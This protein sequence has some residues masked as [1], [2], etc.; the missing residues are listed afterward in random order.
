MKSELKVYSGIRPDEAVSL[1]RAV[2]EQAKRIELLKSSGSNAAAARTLLECYSSMMGTIQGAENKVSADP[3]PTPA[4]VAFKQQIK[5]GQ[6]I[7]SALGN[8]GTS[9]KDES[10][11]NVAA[12][13]RHK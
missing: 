6:S 7:F 2:E 1:A 10:D 8:S 12:E 4:N 9:P 5:Q 13:F 11:V 3:H